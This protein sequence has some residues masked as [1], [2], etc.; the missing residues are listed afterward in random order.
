MSELENKQ[1][2]VT[3]ADTQP[4][5]G[6]EAEGARTEGDDLETLLASYDQQ[7]TRPEPQP[8]PPA[9]S[10]T[11]QPDVKALLEKVQTFEGVANRIAQQE[12]KQQLAETVKDVRGDVPQE[13]VD[14]DLVEAW[15]DARA[16]KEPRLQQAWLQ[17]DANPKQWSRIKSEL[18]R[19]F[20]KKFDKMPD[21]AVTEDRAAVAAAVRGASTKASAEP[22]P[23]LGSMSP[24]EFEKFKSQFF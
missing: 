14:D 5:A 17:K 22:A 15:L 12:F 6:S 21:R 4:K 23:N 8:N 10:A 24:Q 1:P 19:E 13:V 9:T 16:R 7:T 18:G 11:T 20:K 3:D 2:V